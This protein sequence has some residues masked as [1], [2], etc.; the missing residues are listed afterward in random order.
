MIK[1]NEPRN[2]LKSSM[3]K[4]IR[5]GYNISINTNVKFILFCTAHY[6]FIN[7]LEVEYNNAKP[8]T[9]LISNLCSLNLLLF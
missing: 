9:F 4:R 8:N 6:I 7:E 1:G 2:E 3:P 5:Y